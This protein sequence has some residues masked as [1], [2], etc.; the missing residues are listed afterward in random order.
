VRGE[1]ELVF[2]RFLF[3][4]RQGFLPIGPAETHVDNDAVVDDR[5]GNLL[6]DTQ[7]TLSKF[8]SETGRVHA[9]EETWPKNRMDSQGGLNDLSVI[10]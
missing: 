10:L 8:V 2:E 3:R 1:R 4:L 7:T 5:H 9:F 6:L